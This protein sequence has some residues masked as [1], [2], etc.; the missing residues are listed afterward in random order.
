MNKLLVAIICA[1]LATP[2]LAGQTY[3][4]HMK[5]PPKPQP[6]PRTGGANT[7]GL[8]IAGGTI[9]CGAVSLIAYAAY[10]SAT[11][12]RELTMREA[13]IIMWGCVVPIVGGVAFDYLYQA[14]GWQRYEFAAPH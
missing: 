1:A 14:N 9:G 11:Q 8:W 12:H 10:I 6:V 5:P 4:Y 3:Y 2:A 7:T 13:N